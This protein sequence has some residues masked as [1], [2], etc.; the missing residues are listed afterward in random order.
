MIDEFKQS[1]A[2]LIAATAVAVLAIALAGC[3]GSGKA[4]VEQDVAATQHVCASCH[5]ADGLGVSPTFPRLA[6]QQADYIVV[7]LK[8]F[9]DKTR[10]DPH[11]H[12]YMWGMA[13]KL[14]DETIDGLAASYSAMPPATGTAGD[15]A[16]TAAGARI[17]AQGITDRQVPACSACHGDKATGNGQIPRLAGQYRNYIEGQLAAFVS[18]SRANEMM[19]DNSKNLTPLEIAQVAAFVAAQ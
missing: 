10:A 14:S 1:T 13:A 8:S 6:G 5:G 16:E 17:F 2:T 15:P 7:Q 3:A 4:T 18:N 19:H 12:T 9:R 11:A